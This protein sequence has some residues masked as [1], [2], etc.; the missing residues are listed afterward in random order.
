[1]AISAQLKQIPGAAD[2]KVEQ[3]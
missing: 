2:V 3:V 1:E